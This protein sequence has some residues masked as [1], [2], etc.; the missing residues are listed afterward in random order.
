MWLEE[1]MSPGM[2]DHYYDSIGLP[3]PPN[4]IEAFKHF[5]SELLQAFPDLH[6]VVYDIIG[7]ADKVV[8]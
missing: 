6:P 8:T 7:E 1:I 5:Y 4:A 2:I 3:Q